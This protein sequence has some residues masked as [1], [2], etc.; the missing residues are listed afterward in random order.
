MIHQYLS[1]AYWAKGRS[2]D[3][4]RNSMENSLCFGLFERDK[5]IG[6]ARVVTDGEVFAW[7]MDVFVLDEY[8]GQ[9]LGKMLMEHILNSPDL[10]GTKGMG[11]RTRDAHCFYEKLGFGDIPDP[12][13]WMFKKMNA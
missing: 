6:F 11:M 12:E 3:A 9:G 5:Q 7:L 13:S 2:L 1:K 8:Q 4:V 10:D